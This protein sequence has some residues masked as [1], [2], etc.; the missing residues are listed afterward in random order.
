[1]KSILMLVVLIFGVSIVGAADTS[2]IAE[3]NKKVVEAFYNM[4]FRDHK[5]VEA[6][7]LY[8]GVQYRQHNPHVADGKQ[9]F[10]DY[11]STFFPK[12]PEA[13]SEIKRIVAE[14]DLVVLHVHS[15]L[16]KNDR[17]RAIVDIFRVENGKIVEH[18]DVG[19]AIP[20]KAANNNTMF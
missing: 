1:M 18:W 6:M 5:P 11:F 10:K 17:G 19:Q 8:G 15:K 13:K 4:A 14:G 20:E 2:S 7:D 12:N 16:N 9:P 3:K